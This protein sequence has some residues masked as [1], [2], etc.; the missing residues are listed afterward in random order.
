[1]EQILSQTINSCSPCIPLM[2]GDMNATYC[3]GDR[4]SNH[5]YSQ[6]VQNRTFLS[7]LGLLPLGAPKHGSPQPWTYIHSIS[8]GMH[9]GFVE[10]GHSRINDNLLPTAIAHTCKEAMV[11]DLGS[12]SDHT[13]LIATLPTALLQ[14]AIPT[15]PNPECPPKQRALTRPITERDQ[16]LLTHALKDTRVGSLKS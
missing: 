7:G 4:S 2:V 5:S 13:P 10:Y 11:C 1:M 8:P 3:D 14:L 15:I 6:D 16:S 9:S 12:I